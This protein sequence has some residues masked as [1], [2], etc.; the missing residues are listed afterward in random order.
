MP[1]GENIDMDFPRKIYNGWGTYISDLTTV[2]NRFG[3]PGYVYIDK[4]D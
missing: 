2:D 1:Y 3:I 4:S